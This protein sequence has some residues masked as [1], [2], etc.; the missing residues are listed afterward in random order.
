MS[1]PIVTLTLQMLK[2]RENRCST[3]QLCL[4][5][6]TKSLIMFHENSTLTGER[7][8]EDE[9]Y[10]LLK[11]IDLETICMFSVFTFSAMS[12]GD[13]NIIFPYITSQSIQQTKMV[14]GNSKRIALLL[15][16]KAWDTYRQLE[17]LIKLLQC[18]ICTGQSS[19]QLHPILTSQPKKSTK[20]GIIDHQHLLII[21]NISSHKN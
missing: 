7:H 13:C 18:A 15:G 12:R 2:C 14:L 5:L 10:K 19:Y 21:I 11:L 20:F 9:S 3:L 4:S 16:S 1:E 6:E 17:L 8:F